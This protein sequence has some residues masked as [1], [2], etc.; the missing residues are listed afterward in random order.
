MAGMCCRA[1]GNGAIQTSS[2]HYI[3]RGATNS[4]IR[5]VSEWIDAAWALQAVPAT[6]TCITEAALRLHGLITVPDCNYI[7]T[8]GL[9]DHLLDRRVGAFV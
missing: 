9:G 1:C 3:R 8:L 4:F 6:Q 7:H 5:P 2:H